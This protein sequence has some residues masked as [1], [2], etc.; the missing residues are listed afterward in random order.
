MK[1]IVSL[2]KMDLHS[3]RVKSANTK[4]NC[5]WLKWREAQSETRRTARF[6]SSGRR[7]VVE[8]FIV[9]IG[10]GGWRGRG[11]GLRMLTSP[12]CVSLMTLEACAGCFSSRREVQT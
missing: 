10:E 12:L 6:W 5:F 1:I 8:C 11:Y 7:E 2:M 3:Q 9:Y 4:R